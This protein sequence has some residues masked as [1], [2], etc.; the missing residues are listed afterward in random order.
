MKTFFQRKY[1]LPFCSVLT[2]IGALTYKGTFVDNSVLIFPVICAAVLLFFFLGEKIFREK[3]AKDFLEPDSLFFMVFYVF[4]FPYILLYMAGLS[5]YDK[6]VFYNPDTVPTA[7]YFCLFCL[8]VF[9]AGYGHPFG[10]RQQSKPVD[11]R[12][13]L[14]RTMLFSKIL[15]AICLLFF[16]VPL[17]VLGNAVF[18]DYTLLIDVGAASY[19]GRLFWLGQYLGV[20]GL[21]VYSVC[22]GLLYK[23]FMSGPFKFV[24]IFYVLSFLIIGDRGGFVYMAVIPVIAFNLFQ[25]KISG[26]VF[27]SL[28]LA[29]M[30]VIPII[31]YS[32]TRSIYNPFQM[33]RS[34]SEG[35]SESLFVSALNELGTTIKTVSITMHFVPDRYE[36]WWG[37]SYL[38][39]M[40]LV[41]PNVQGM[42]T[43]SGSPGAWLTETAFG[44][45]SKTH[46]RG[47]SIA[48]EAYRNFGPVLG[49][50]V[51]LL[52]GIAVKKAYGYLLRK[53]GVISGVAY[54]S[55]ISSVVLWVRND[56][57]LA[58]RTIL[59]SVAIAMAVT[60]ITRM[61]QNKRIRFKR[62][63]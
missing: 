55:I 14:E 7:V 60:L 61:A 28:L 57:A 43:S 20:A 32:R 38:Y 22:S 37:S 47:G 59:W 13:T 40:S 45:L 56:S 6:E 51:F 63:S 34:Y 48:M 41:V 30:L 18:S 4:H 29:F 17:L 2:L 23:K 5:G 46:G 39:S 58:P 21:A 25:K 52:L 53:P 24:A 44:D 54:F 11:N 62:A 12:V 35:S 42:R 3:G 27:A 8:I 50:G 31:A 36:Y 1:Y 10:S 49:L 26:R 33:F 9:L 16:W 15:I 19:L